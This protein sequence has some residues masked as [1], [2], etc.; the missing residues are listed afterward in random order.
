VTIFPFS[1]ATQG[2]FRRQI[3]LTFVVGFFFLI[4]AFSVYLVKSEG[5]YLYRDSRDDTTSLA[6]SLAASSLSWV[7]ANDVVGLQEVVHSFQS[8]PELRYAMVISLSG[9]VL[10]HT[11][12]SKVG[13]FVADEPSLAM[14]KAP[15][16]TRVMIDDA[17]VMDVAVP[18]ISHEHHVGWARVA[19]V[20]TRGNN[21]LRMMIWRSGIFVLLASALSLFAAMLIANRLGHRIGSLVQ[22]AEQVQAGNFDVRARVPGKADEITKLGDSLNQMLDALAHNEK[23]L[24]QASL[25]TRSLI[26]ASLDPLVTI[27]A[28]GKITD[29]NEATEKATGR[30]RTELIGTDFSEYFTEPDKAR[31]GYQKVFLL[32]SVVDYPLTLRHKDG[33]IIDV[34]YNASVYRKGSGEVLG[35]FA[36]AR[37]VTERNKAEAAQREGEALLQTTIKILPVGLWVFDADGKIV[38]SNDAAQQI[39]AGVRYVGI[40]QLGEY[41]GWRLNSGI[42]MGTHDWAGAR[43]LEKGETS[44]GEEIEIECFDGTHKIILDSAVPL[45]NSDGS[46][47]GA[48]TINQDITARKRAEKALLDSE[49]RY[50]RIT[51]GLTDYQYSVRIENGRAVETT[52]SPAC[53]KVTGYTADEFAAN[54]YLWIQL[55]APA[56]RELVT[57]HVSQILAGKEIPPIEH[58][59]VRK[60]GE[61]RWVSDT[62]IL[63]K[64]ASGKLLSYD[65][66]IKDITEHKMAENKIQELNRDLEQRVVKRTAQLEAANK[67]LE[68]FAYSVSHDLRTPL[69]AIDGFSNILQ[70]DYAGKLG[71]EGKRLLNVVRDNSRNMAQ[72]IDDI[73]KFSRASRSEIAYAEIDMEGLAHEVYEE[74][75][76]ATEHGLK[77]EI[78]HLPKAQGD[79]AMMRQVFVNLLSNAIKFSHQK[80]NSMIRV[81]AAVEGDETIY[82]VQDNGAGFDMQYADRLFGV[83]QR[84]HTTEEFEGTGIGLAIIK[85]IITRHGGRTWA[86]GK[87]NEGATIYFALPLEEKKA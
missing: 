62:T 74:L 87:V 71:D 52:Q 4:S 53:A 30:G 34:L 12:T 31:A 77:I 55:V 78:G 51:E 18:I 69:R 7:L 41:K 66:V 6:Q 44:I 54:P 9:R 32:G 43:A 40:A 61:P 70:E 65:G 22:V 86:E 21:K 42:P 60:D 46:I 81:G 26:E 5:D 36:A 15:P 79:R 10:G 19:Q 24:R 84:L 25:Y 80:E 1:L 50:R 38:F 68:A 14:L 57:K 49:A 27:S 11:D 28:E 58:R 72:L 56:D 17:S 45:R 75:R 2:S 33:R 20:S 64:D 67:E 8:H 48:V 73:L 59:I 76:P 37:D 29:V 13:Q 63:F 85:R 47:R 23:E 39:W 3:I 82:F 16:A 83:F 35:V